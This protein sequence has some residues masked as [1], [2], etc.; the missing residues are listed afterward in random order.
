MQYLLEFEQPI[1]TIE[2]EHRNTLLPI[3]SL[4]S[5]LSGSSAVGW[6]ARDRWRHRDNIRESTSQ[7]VERRM[8]C[9]TVAEEMESLDGW[10]DEPGSQS[11]CW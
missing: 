8:L 1:E 9:L 6:R 4:C 10:M 3:T 7:C 2:T 5:S 11:H